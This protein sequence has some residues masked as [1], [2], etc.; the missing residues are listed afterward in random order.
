MTCGEIP[1]VKTFTSGVK[2]E[3]KR[4]VLDS[5]ASNHMT[6]VREIFT[7][8]NS[9][10]HGSVKF[11]DGSVVEIEGIGTILFVGKNGDHRL[12][13]GVYLIPKLTPNIISL[14]QL[15]DMGYEIEIKEGVMKVRDENQRL[16]ARVERSSNRLYMLQM[17]IAQPVSLGRQS[18]GRGAAGDHSFRRFRSRD[19]ARRTS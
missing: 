6:G 9:N 18:S 12:L 19:D 8:L 1:S 14:G 7:E 15:D 4:W 2:K 10:V 5:G 17:E 11:G 16:L 3:G 13:A